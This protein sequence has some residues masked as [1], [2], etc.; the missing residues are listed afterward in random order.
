MAWLSSLIDGP[1]ACFVGLLC[2]AHH[3]HDAHL[4]ISYTMLPP[5]LNLVF[6]IFSCLEVSKHIASV[7]RHH[8]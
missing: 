1:S 8:L 7:A 4:Q 6:S 5:S 2:N 3:C